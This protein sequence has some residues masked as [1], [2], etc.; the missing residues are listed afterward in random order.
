MKILIGVISFQYLTGA[1]IYVY[2][3]SRELVRR[4]HQVV[5]ASVFGGDLAE[6]AT[7]AGVYLFPLREIKRLTGKFDIL[8]LNEKGPAELLLDAF[9]DT[10]AVATVHSQFPCEAPC[11]SPRIRKY[12]YIRPDILPFVTEVHR[13]PIG[14]TILV[15]N[16]FDLSRFNRKITRPP[17]NRKII[18][19]AGTLD[20]M[21]RAPIL[22]TLARARKE[23]AKVWLIGRNCDYSSEELAEISRFAKI[24]P[25]CWH[26]EDYIRSADETS[27]I[28]LGR[29]TIEGWLCGRPGRIYILDQKYNIVST[30]LKFP[31]PDAE[32]RFD[33]RNTTAQIEAVYAEALK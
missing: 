22:D 24:V 6:K 13:I 9:P 27:G 11:L 2:E 26:I 14:K 33:I 23:D 3:L 8:H 5:V 18:L 28:F 19:F 31:P 20:K 29:T 10:P 30:E 15:Y 21:R 1:E 32:E 17:N 16:G 7:E 4:G 12:I 25:E